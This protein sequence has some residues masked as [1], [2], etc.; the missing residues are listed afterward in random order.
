LGVGLT[1]TPHAGKILPVFPPS[2]R[3]LRP[4]QG[5]RDIKKKKK[6]VFSWEGN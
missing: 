6:K 4:T 1:T 5:Y 2:W 3:R